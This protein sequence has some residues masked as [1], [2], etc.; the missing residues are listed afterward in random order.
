MMH[1]LSFIA[2]KDQQVLFMSVRLCIFL[3][4]ENGF[5]LICLLR[6]YICH[7]SMQEI[8]LVLL[9]ITHIENLFSCN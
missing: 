2:F 9:L 8:N 7:M 4:P 3:L 6:A 5:H 1:G